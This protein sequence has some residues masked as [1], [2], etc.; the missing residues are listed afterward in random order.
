MALMAVSVQIS[1]A[2]IAKYLLN[3]PLGLYTLIFLWKYKFT[4]KVLERIIIILQDATIITCY[5]IFVANYNYITSYSLDFFAL[6]I[7]IL[8]E[9][10]TLIPKLVQFCKRSDD[11]NDPSVNPENDISVSKLRRNNS[12]V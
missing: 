12:F 1:T 2:S 3:V 9:I 11:D 6:A 10:I 7:V 8:L 5:N 4:L